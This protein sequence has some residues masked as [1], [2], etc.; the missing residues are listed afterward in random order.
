MYSINLTINKFTLYFMLAVSSVMISSSIELFRVIGL[1]S[2][3]SSILFAS[4][5]FLIKFSLKKINY[6]P[7]LTVFFILYF[8]ISALSVIINDFNVT[9]FKRLIQIFVT[10]S[11]FY[12]S[13]V[14]SQGVI[15]KN[16]KILVFL[17]LSLF[18]LLLICLKFIEFFVNPNAAGLVGF[19]LFTTLLFFSKE[20]YFFLVF[21]V[22][23]IVTFASNSRTSIMAVILVYLFFYL[24]PTIS[25]YRLYLMTLIVFFSTLTIFALFTTG[26]IFEEFFLTTS[27]LSRVFFEKNLHNRSD[28]WLTLFYVIENNFIFGVGAGKTFGDV[29]NYTISGHNLYLQTSMQI[30]VVGLVVLL[31]MIFSFWLILKG[32]LNNKFGK[33]AASAFL[34]LLLIN[35]FEITFFQNNLVF[36]L[37]II[38][39]I[40]LA[41]GYGKKIENSI[42]SPA[43]P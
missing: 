3:Y 16:N 41:T 8:F 4:Y 9:G 25:R 36:S 5:L 37:P 38:A 27:N 18:I 34:G 28:I 39:L 7:F 26:F 29:S 30:G 32:C 12:I 2:F 43:T 14:Y 23:L 15:S 17:W 19:V 20:R 33:V 42:S 1:L 13:F 31:L 35:F 22:S 21:C 24:L 6:F 10:Y 40:G 11:V